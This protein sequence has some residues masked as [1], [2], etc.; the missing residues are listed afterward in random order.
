MRVKFD[1]RLATGDVERTY[2]VESDVTE[3]HLRAVEMEEVHELDGLALA[4]GAIIDATRLIVKLETDGE[5]L[6][7]L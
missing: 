1:V 6:G 3:C 4:Q 5:Y 7:S 2:A